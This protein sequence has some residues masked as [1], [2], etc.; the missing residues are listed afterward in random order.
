MSFV[1]VLII[2]NNFRFVKQL[3]VDK[4]VVVVSLL[5]VLV[6]LHGILH[7]GMESVYNYNPLEILF[8]NT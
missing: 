1:L 2:A 3:P 4:L 8:T 5:G 6:G 7:L